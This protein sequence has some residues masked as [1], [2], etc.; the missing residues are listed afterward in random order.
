MQ[1][2]TLKNSGWNELFWNLCVIFNHKTLPIHLR[3]FLQMVFSTYHNF[4]IHLKAYFLLNKG[5]YGWLSRLF[6]DCI[7]V[8]DLLFRTRKKASSNVPFLIWVKN[9][10][11]P[12]FKLLNSF[13]W[14]IVWDFKRSSW[15]NMA[16]SAL[17]LGELGFCHFSATNMK[18]PSNL[19]M[20]AA[21]LY[22]PQLQGFVLLNIHHFN[23]SGLRMTILNL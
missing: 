16:I 12:S 5:D 1:V 7:H 11:Y 20:K 17:C 19:F 3:S 4:E 13:N 15:E 23:L 8:E 14:W 21:V 18:S 9:F 6:I 22:Q 10:Y 2:T